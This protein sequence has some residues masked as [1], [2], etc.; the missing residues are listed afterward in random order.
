MTVKTHIID[1][2]LKSTE[3]D[4]VQVT[5]GR[6]IQ[7]IPDF[8]ALPFSQR[9]QSAAFVRSR[10]ILIVWDDDESNLIA[11][12]EHIQKSIVDLIWLTT[13]PS[14]KDLSVRSELLSGSGNDDMDSSRR[15]TLWQTCY[16]TV[17]IMLLMTCIALGYRKVSIEQ[18]HDYNWRRWL[19]VLV[20]PPAAWLGLVRISV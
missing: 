11:R 3:T 17:A 20:F 5:Q 16:T 14:E 8:E 19:F 2:V 6:R 10:Q 7:I 12:A 13:K 18:V 9:Y 1:M 15:V 4:Y